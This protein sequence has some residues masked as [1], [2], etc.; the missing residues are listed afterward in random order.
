MESPP[1]YMNQRILLIYAMTQPAHLSNS[2]TGSDP[3]IG[4]LSQ[5]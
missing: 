4:G 1:T 2:A 3:D 5:Y